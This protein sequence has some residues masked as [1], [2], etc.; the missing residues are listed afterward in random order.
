MA[1]SDRDIQL[2]LSEIGMSFGSLPVLS[3]LT[4]EV[5]RGEFI[6]LLGP[7]GCGKTTTLNLIAGYFPPDTGTIEIGGVDVTALPAYRRKTAMVFQNYALFPH[8]NVSRNVAFGLRMR[9]G[10]SPSKIDDK[11]TAALDLVKMGGMQDRYPHQLS[12]GQ[13]QRVALARALVVEP[14][15]L[16]LDEPLSNLDAN[17]REEMQIELRGLQRSIDITTLLVTHDQ[18]EAF[19]VSDRVA[20]MHAGNLEQVGTPEDIYRSPATE[21][22]ANFVGRMNWI[23]GQITQPGL[24]ETDLGDDVRLS[25]PVRTAEG[26]GTRG[27]LLVRPE[28]VFLSP[29]PAGAATEIEG[30][31]LSRIYLGPTTHFHIRVGDAT[32]VAYVSG[33]PGLDT[34]SVF[35][36][37]SPEQASFMPK[38][39]AAARGP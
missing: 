36:S 7:S 10:L 6:T 30:R 1:D 8:L 39:G 19:I 5:R 24:F 22:V 21:R 3:G 28:R 26:P 34:D 17:L 38:A 33:S 31:V 25:L 11:V 2:R 23:E 27:H 9:G 13:Q 16:L 14:A 35:V 12:G 15:V 32:L 37:W 18:E 4:L 20:V 29:E